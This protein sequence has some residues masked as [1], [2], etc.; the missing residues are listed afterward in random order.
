MSVAYWNTNTAHNIYSIVQFHNKS[1]LYNN[2]K[3]KAKKKLVKFKNLR[4]TDTRHDREASALVRFWR[5]FTEVTYSQ[6]RLCKLGSLISSQPLLSFL[7]YIYPNSIYN[8]SALT[9]H[10]F[11]LQYG[12]R[13][14]AEST[15]SWP[16]AGGIRCFHPRGVD[17][18]GAV[19]CCHGI[20]GDCQWIFMCLRVSIDEKT[21]FGV[22]PTDFGV[23]GQ[24][25]W[26]WTDGLWF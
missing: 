5:P 12:G 26:L 16:S 11:T 19:W 15:P 7:N 24:F 17:L 2:S 9:W 1:T 21:E 8:H 10:R 3:E 25:G 18:G 6:E 22:L 13:S 4:Q 23:L 14:G 20:L